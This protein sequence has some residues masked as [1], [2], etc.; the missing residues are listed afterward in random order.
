MPMPKFFDSASDRRQAPRTKLVEIAYLGMGPENGG[1]VLDV[2]DGGLSFHSV[3]PVQPAQEIRFLLSLRGH[4]RIEGAG[5]VVWTNEM[6]TVCGLRFT[7]L[8]SGAREH[9]NN[10]TNQTRTP[11]AAREES[12]TQAPQ[13][14]PALPDPGEFAPSTNAIPVFTIP[15]VSGSPLTFSESR[16]GWQKPALLWIMFAVLASTLSFAA[17]QVGVRVGKSQTTPMA[18]TATQSAQQENPQD[19]EI[20]PVP[21]PAA[22]SNANAAPASRSG[23]HGGMTPEPNAAAS[24][25]NGMAPVPSPA[26]ATSTP[27]GA[28]RNA[29]K[30]EDA[31]PAGA[32]S[33]ISGAKPSQSP[34]A[35]KSQFKA[36][37]AYLNGDNG[38]K[39]VPAAVHLLWAAIADGNPDAEVT[40]ADLFAT[41]DGIAKDCDQARVLL[42]AASK[43]GNSLAEERL[44]DLD[45]NGCQ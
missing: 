13:E 34:D 23:S 5:Q 8:S 10:W 36:A 26:L 22:S 20:F 3:A 4:S 33:T 18:H 19:L 24:A 7:S 31:T 43:A 11:V 15:A 21:P 41:G 37:L 30:Y 38:R 6:H 45:T 27:S 17:Y 44:Q 12:T 2:S 1:L 28:L 14:R 35:G 29:S 25:P 16:S 32:R 40:L 9:L 42:K 39:N